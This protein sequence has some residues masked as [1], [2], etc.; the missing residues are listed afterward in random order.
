[1]IGSSRRICGWWWRTSASAATDVLAATGTFAESADILV[2]GIFGFVLGF[3]PCYRMS[4]KRQ[5]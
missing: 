5:K 1:V 4:K 2:Q 3:M